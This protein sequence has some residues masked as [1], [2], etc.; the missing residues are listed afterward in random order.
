MADEAGALRPEQVD[1]LRVC[2]H[3]LHSVLRLHFRQ[4]GESY[5]SLAP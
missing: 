1:D 3:G 5:F 4:E 2:L